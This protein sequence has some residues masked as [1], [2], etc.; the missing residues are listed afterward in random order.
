[1]YRCQICE[2]VVPP[3]TRTHKVVVQT[4]AK[5]YAAREKPSSRGG[6][7]FRGRGRFQKRKPMDPGGE[8]HEIVRELTVC[9]ACAE[10]YESQAPA[11]I[12][13]EEPEAVETTE[14]SEVAETTDA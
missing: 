12:P 1:M 11:V 7:G 2:T 3:G 6:G 8:G 5:E 13:K 10:Q 4:R 9:P 14:D